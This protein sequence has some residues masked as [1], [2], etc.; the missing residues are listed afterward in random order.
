[1]LQ[2]NAILIQAYIVL[3]AVRQDEVFEVLPG[4]LGTTSRLKDFFMRNE[5]WHFVKKRFRLI[6]NFLQKNG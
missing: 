1:M 6:A 4:W 3:R 2:I 5:V